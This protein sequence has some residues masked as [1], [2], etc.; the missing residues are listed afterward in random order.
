LVGEDAESCVLCGG[1]PAGIVDGVSPEGC[2]EIGAS[3][4]SAD[5]LTGGAM[6]VAAVVAGD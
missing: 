6:V 4:D 5:V 2:G 1:V 3:A